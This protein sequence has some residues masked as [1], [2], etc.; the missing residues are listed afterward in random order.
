MRTVPFCAI[1][2]ALALLTTACGGGG[3][4]AADAAPAAAPRDTAEL[5]LE[6]RELDAVTG[7]S[8]AETQ[9]RLTLG[10]CNS[11]RATLGLAA[12]EPDPLLYTGR[13]N[14]VFTERR[15]YSA[16]RAATYTE[17]PPLP[18]LVDLER[19]QKDPAP[20][21]SRTAPDCSK[22]ELRAQR[23]G[24]LW[25]DG[26]V[27]DLNY[28]TK[29]AVGR[30]SAADFTAR[31]SAFV[32]TAS[33]I[34]VPGVGSCTLV[35]PKSGVQPVGSSL[36]YWKHFPLDTRL[37]LPWLLQSDNGA[38]S[39]LRITNKALSASTGTPLDAALFQPPTDFTRRNP[40]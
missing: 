10:S 18:V 30:S 23:S 26:V 36:C 38:S 31:E 19:W 35:A 32:A 33:S 21:A 13:L 11:L 25:A 20:P 40:S 8:A 16:G 15:Y 7:K 37:N 34:E 2:F 17:A 22:L 3:S 1:P 39:G 14:G 24:K 9:L 28:Q 12:Q 5:V 6:R 29:E 4:A 27:W